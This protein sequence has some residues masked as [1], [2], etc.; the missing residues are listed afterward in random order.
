MRRKS[1]L[2]A[3]SVALGT[4]LA[5]SAAK[6]QEKAYKVGYLADLSGPMQDN[7]GPILEGFEF[8]V[9][10]LNA[11][12][13]INGAPFQVAVRDDQLDATRAASMALELATSEGVNSIWGMSQTRTHLAVYQTAARNRIPATAM[14]S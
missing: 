1:R 11:G 3:V 9:K 7:Y 5:L 8:H 13:G 12:G 14:F 6:A 2:A 4:V 10:Q